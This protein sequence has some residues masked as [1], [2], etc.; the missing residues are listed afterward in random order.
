[1]SRGIFHSLVARNADRTGDG[2][3]DLFELEIYI[4]AIRY[5]HFR[6]LNLINELAFLAGDDNNACEMRNALDGFVFIVEE[7]RGEKDKKENQRH[8]DVVVQAAP[9]V[10]PKDVS[11]D[12]AP[13]RAHGR[14]SAIKRWRCCFGLLPVYLGIHMMAN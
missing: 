2:F 1:M 8:H 12:C 7:T 3:D 9:L 4:A 11:A 14:D 13:D 5:V 10:R 6:G